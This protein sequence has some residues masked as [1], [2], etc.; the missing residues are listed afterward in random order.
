MSAFYSNI[1]SNLEMQGH[2]HQALSFLESVMKAPAVLLNT[3]TDVFG[4]ELDLNDKVLT[5]MYMYMLAWLFM[6]FVVPGTS[7]LHIHY[8][9]Y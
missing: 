7:Y 6:L 5:A 4:G 1:N 9:I 3:A 8:V 2:M